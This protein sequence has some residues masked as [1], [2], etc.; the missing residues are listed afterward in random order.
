MT[1]LCVL[2]TMQGCGGPKETVILQPTASDPAK[3]AAESERH[4]P[5]NYQR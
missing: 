3:K 5:S 1:V 2:P 4:K